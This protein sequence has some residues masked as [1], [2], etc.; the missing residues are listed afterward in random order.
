MDTPTRLPLDDTP[1]PGPRPRGWGLPL[2][3]AMRDDYLGFM[4]A[5]HREHGDLCRMR[6]AWEEAWSLGSPERVREALVEQADALVRWER[7]V[8]VFA[9]IFGQSVLTTEGETWQRLRRMLQPAFTP[10]R[11]AAQAGLMREAAAQALDAAVPPGQDEAA[12]DMDTLFA[13][14]T[15]DVILRTLFGT[16]ADD[17]T[18]ARAID[19]TRTL[20]ETAMREMFMPFT[21]PDVL[22]LPGKA[23]KRAAM[24]TLR[25]LVA[26]RIA[27]R[28]AR[29]GRPGDTQ[30]DL[31]AGLLALRDEAGGAALD[32]TALFEQC[33]V[34]FQAGHDTGATALLW[35]SRRMAAHPEAAERA[36]AEVDAALAGRDPGPD[37]LARLPWLTATLKE[38]LRLHPPIAGLMTRRTTRPIRVGGR[39]IARGALLYVTPWLLQRD[40]RSFPEPDAFRP[41]RFLPQ[42]PPPPRGA[43][44]PFGLGPRV[45]IG[46]HFAMLEMTLVAAMLLR[47][48]EIGP[49]PADGAEGEPVLNVTLRPAG[50]T[51]LRLRRRPAA[52]AP[53]RPDARPLP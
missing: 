18:S 38:A 40:A 50:P 41:E 23:A 46:Q 47:R 42:A 14:V 43:W 28:R 53:G 9:Q 37:D 21:L 49:G 32:D 15:M 7:G 52:A 31:L 36:R 35:W 16:P 45:C 19:A 3:R 11:V 10:R 27:A 5:L 8:A 30:D 22:P 48:F 26:E 39:T 2:L 6:L 20:S 12:V 44:I 29:L 17:A 34:T 1:P 13:R 4:A 25:A 24:R 33:M 51:R